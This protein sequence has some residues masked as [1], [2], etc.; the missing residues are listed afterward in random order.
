MLQDLFSSK[1]RVEI[2]QLF[3]FNPKNSFYLRQIATLVGRPINAVQREV[4]RFEKSRLFEKTFEGNR[5]YFRINEQHPIYNELK[6]IFLKCAGI[7]ETIKNHMKDSGGI[8]TAFIYGSYAQ[9]N[10]NQA[11]DIDLFVLGDISSRELSKL[12]SNPKKEI[13]REINYAIFTP[14]ELR[15]KTEQND[16]YILNVLKGEKI[17]II[18]GESDIKAALK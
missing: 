1:A 5:T 17:F 9:N 14:Q 18:G 7:A 3:L 4:R 13:G 10:E 2:L 12:L 11:S 16:N 6:S 15:N 8:Q